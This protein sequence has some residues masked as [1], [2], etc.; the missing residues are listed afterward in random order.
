MGRLD[1]CQP[2]LHLRALRFTSGLFGLTSAALGDFEVH[3]KTRLVSGPHM[4]PL[5]RRRSKSSAWKFPISADVSWLN[6][7]SKQEQSN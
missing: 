2:G 5:V 4:P 3:L 7:K 1:S 6:V